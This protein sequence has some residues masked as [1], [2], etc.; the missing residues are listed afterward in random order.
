MTTVYSRLPI[1]GY[2]TVGT[3]TLRF[4]NHTATIDST[5]LTSG[6]R[7]ELAARGY[8]VDAPPTGFG[9]PNPTLDQQATVDIATHTPTSVGPSLVPPGFGEAA[10]PPTQI[11]APLRDAAVDPRPGD[12]RPWRATNNDAWPT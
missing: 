5:L 1:N 6:D 2:I 3:H 8:G 12:N 11:G 10:V 4:A 7:A 9:T